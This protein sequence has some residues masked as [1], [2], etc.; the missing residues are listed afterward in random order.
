M[1]QSPSCPL[2]YKLPDM[3]SARAK[4]KLPQYLQVRDIMNTPVISSQALDVFSVGDSS[5]AQGQGAHGLLRGGRSVSTTFPME[6]SRNHSQSIDM[7]FA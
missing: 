1:L 4:E 5:G 7:H 2:L 3:S 6:V